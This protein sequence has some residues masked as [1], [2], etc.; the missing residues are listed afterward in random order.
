MKVK[1]VVILAFV[2][3]LLAACGGGNNNNEVNELGAKEI[4]ELVNDYTTRTL[5]ADSASI[6]STELIVEDNN[7]KEVYELPEEEFFV[8]IAPFNN[9]TH[10]CDIHSLTGCQGELVEEDFDLYITDS[11]G[12]VV[13][14]ETMKTEGNGF[15]DLWLPRNETYQVVITQGDKATE[16]E[17]STFENDNTCITTMQLN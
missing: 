10:P 9:V 12:D 11:S 13:L 6:T 15:I 5:Q 4:K 16:S 8:S 14:D 17:L 7:K 3:V 1:I 2:L